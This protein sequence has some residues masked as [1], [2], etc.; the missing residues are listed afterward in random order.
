[1]RYGRQ[2]VDRI[3][4]KIAVM[5]YRTQSSS[6]KIFVVFA[7]MGLAHLAANYAQAQM[8]KGYWKG[9]L[10]REGT[11]TVPV[12]FRF[13]GEQNLSFV[14]Q[15]ES[16]AVSDLHWVGDSLFFA[17]PVFESSFRLK[18]HGNNELSGT[19][20]KGTSRGLQYWHMQA[21][22]AADSFRFGKPLANA[23]NIAGKWTVDFVRTNGSQRPAV[24]DFVQQP[25]GLITG[26]IRTPSGDYRYLDGLIRNDSLYLGTF[27]GSHAFYF[28]AV[29]QNDST[30]KQG[31]FY[32]GGW[33]TETFTATKNALAALPEATFM[34]AVPQQLAPLNFCF[35]DV[36]GKEICLSDQRFAGKA[37]ILQMM[38]S[39]CPNC[40][41]ET[42]WLSK[43]YATERPA[44]V[45]VISLA[46]ELSTDMDRSVKSLEKFRQRFQVPYPMLITG[47]AVGDD[48]K[49]AKTL[50]GVPEISSFPT[51]LFL[52]KDKRLVTAHIGFYGPAAPDDFADFQEKFAAI[53]HQLS[54]Q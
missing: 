52:N 22:A 42:Q 48:S 35:R 18:L 53:I 11:L 39:W 26:T 8:A 23:K 28:A 40:M 50:P 38:G 16:I 14:N 25:N 43:W 44:G 7:T 54:G 49:I 19:W 17:M 2:S 21:A 4:N 13:D 27:D 37:V 32:A 9:T 3:L 31:V 36:T 45:E 47:A 34:Q 24:G 46:Y 12:V 10:Q 30:V 29:V 1:M 20:V 6:F 33:P 51:L 15:G 41:D 5:L